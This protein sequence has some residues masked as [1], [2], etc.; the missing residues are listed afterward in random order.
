VCGPEDE[1]DTVLAICCAHFATQQLA[2]NKHLGE[3]KG[4]MEQRTLK[5]FQ[6]I[7][8]V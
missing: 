5:G 6:M 7:E 3:R 1:S 8:G 2:S 4:A